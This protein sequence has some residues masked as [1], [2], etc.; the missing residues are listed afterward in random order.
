VQLN[1]GICGFVPEKFWFLNSFFNFESFPYN[2]PMLKTSYYNRLAGNSFDY[3]YF[4][5]ILFSIWNEQKQ[6]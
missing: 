2:Q 3:G 4:Q 1:G 5:M 6:K